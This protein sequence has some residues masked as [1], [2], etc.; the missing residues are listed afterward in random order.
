MD[1]NKSAQ[2]GDSNNQGPWYD[3]QA[4][5]FHPYPAAEEGSG[6]TIIAPPPLDKRSKQTILTLADI[7]MTPSMA[8]V[9]FGTRLLPDI[10]TKGESLS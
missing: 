6:W 2:E 10:A 8:P 7:Q 3:R 5:A 9:L 1:V 4:N